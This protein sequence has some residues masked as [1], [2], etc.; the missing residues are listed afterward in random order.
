MIKDLVRPELQKLVPYV[1]HQV[2]YRIKLDAN[3]SPFELPESIRKK[4]ADY[5]LKGPGLN[6]YPDNESVEL[7]KTIAKYWNVDADEVIVGTGSNQ[8]IQLIITVFV[9]KGEKVLYPWPTFSM[10]KINTLIAGGEPVAFPLDKEKDFVLDTDKFIEAVKTENAK[11]VFLCNPN[12]PTGGLVPLEH[13][14]KIVKE[15]KSSIIVVDEAYAEF[16]PQSVIPLVKKY[17]NLV[18]L[19]TFSKAYL[20]A[21]ARCGYSISGIEIANEINKVRPTYNVSSLTQ[22]IAK[23]VFEEQEEMQKMIR[24]LI[25]QRGELEKSLKKIKD[26]CIYPSHANYILVKVPEAEMI[27]KELQKRGILIRSFP[28]DPVLYDC[29]RITVGTKEQNDIFLEEFS[30]IINNF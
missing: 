13:I 19:R 3:E 28:N 23:M 17:E 5:F 24:Y 21:G 12:N 11:V 30:D 18:V 2:P 25:E 16:C 9:G 20:L 15:C 29:I 8:L 6:I 22:L 7:R 14:E 10:Y 4:L 1:S 26:V 27:S